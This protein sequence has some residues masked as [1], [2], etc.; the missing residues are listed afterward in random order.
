MTTREQR[1][2]ERQEFK[3]ALE[4]HELYE[5]AAL[6]GKTFG[7]INSGVITDSKGKEVAKYGRPKEEGERIE[8]ATGY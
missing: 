2:K 3:Q 7:R 4:T 6:V 8:P 1:L 5:F